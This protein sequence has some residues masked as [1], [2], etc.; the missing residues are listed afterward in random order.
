MYLLQILPFASLFTLSIG[1]TPSPPPSVHFKCEY[2]ARIGGWNNCAGSD[3]QWCTDGWCSTHPHCGLGS[4]AEG[5]GAGNG[6][7]DCYCA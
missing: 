4:K 7:C 3:A 2:P 5:V 1:G 6:F